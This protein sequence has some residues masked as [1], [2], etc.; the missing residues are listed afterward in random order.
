MEERKETPAVQQ[1]VRHVCECE[2]ALKDVE[3]KPYCKHWL[4]C[5]F[6]EEKEKV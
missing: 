5:P 1:P 4:E 6:F 3:K 2:K